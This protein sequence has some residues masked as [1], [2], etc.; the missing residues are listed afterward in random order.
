MVQL[1]KSRTAYQI[2][3]LGRIL[4]AWLLQASASHYKMQAVGI[5]LSGTLCNQQPQNKALWLI[6]RVMTLQKWYSRHNWPAIFSIPLWRCNS[7]LFF[8]SHWLVLLQALFIKTF[9]LPTQRQF[10]LAI[11]T[12]HSY[13]SSR[14]RHWPNPLWEK[15]KDNTNS[16]SCTCICYGRGAYCLRSLS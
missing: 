15:G 13:H 6:T 8:T 12:I 5:Q 9:Y 1:A 10:L 16:L 14:Q 11:T 2:I 4:P 7:F 3:F